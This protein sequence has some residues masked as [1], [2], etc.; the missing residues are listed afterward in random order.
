[1]GTVVAT[2]QQS[3]I[4][5][6][7]GGIRTVFPDVCRTPAAPSPVPLPYPNIA[8][9]ANAIQQKKKATG[10]GAIGVP[11]VGGSGV[12]SLASA[13]TMGTAATFARQA[14]IQQLKGLLGQINTKLLTLSTS[15]P[16]QWQSLIEEYLLAAGALYVTLYSK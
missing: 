9:T 14:E 13:M 10:T 4:H 6:A 3:V 7:S 16:N 2:N 12:T 15:D 5:A 8:T 11:T 1:M